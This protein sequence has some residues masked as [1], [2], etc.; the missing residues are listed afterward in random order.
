MLLYVFST[1]LFRILLVAFVFFEFRNK[2][3]LA[4]G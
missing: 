3:D 1:F 2:D 4:Q